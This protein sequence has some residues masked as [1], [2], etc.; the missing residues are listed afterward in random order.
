M[1]KLIFRNNLLALFLFVSSVAL[2]AGTIIPNGVTTDKVNVDNIQLDGNTVSTTNTNGDLTFDMN[3]TGSVIY[4]DL[5]ASAVLSL[6]ASKKLVSGNTLSGLT[7][8]S[9]AINGSN[10]VFGTATN[11]NR[12]RLPT[13][14]TTNLSGLTNTA[15]LLGYDSTLGKPVYNDGTGWSAIGGNFTNPMTTN[16]DMITQAAG[17]PARVGIGTTGYVWTSNGSAPSWGQITDSGI[18][19]GAAIARSK[20]AIGTAG[21]LINDPLFG[22]MSSESQLA[23]IRGGTGVN[24]AGSLTYGANNITLTTSGATSVTLPT[25]GTLAKT[26]SE[27]FT[28]PTIDVEHLT[29]QGSDP[30]TPSAGT[31]KLYAKSTGVYQKDSNGVVS[32]VGSGSGSGKNYTQDLYDGTS[33]VGINQYA[34]AAASSPVDGTGG[35]PGGAAAAIRSS[36][37][38]RSTGDIKL[39]K[40]ANNRQGEGWSYDIVVDESDRAGAKPISFSA[41]VK[42]ST[43]YVTGDL[44]FFV[45][46]KDAPALITPVCFGQTDGTIA[47][48]DTAS[49]LYCT[50]TPTSADDDY[51][52]IIHIATTSA[53]AWDFDLID[54][55]TGVDPPAAASIITPWVAYTPTYTG[56]GTVGTS[57][58][59]SRR[60]GDSL[61]VQGY[62][63]CGVATAVPGQLT[64]G[65]NGVNANV[66]ASNSVIPTN[67]IA[68]AGGIS[69]NGALGYFPLAIQ[70]AGYIQ[71]GLAYT[72]GAGYSI[73]NGNVLCATTNSIS[74]RAS[75]PIAGWTSGNLLSSS[76]LNLQTADPTTATSSTKTATAT[77]RYHAHTGNGIALTPGKWKLGGKVTFFSSGGSAA[78][79]TIGAGFYAANGADTNTAPALLSTLSSSLTV[80][81]NIP[82]G[83]LV[84]LTGLTSS[85]YYV[86]VPEVE[87]RVLSNTTVYLDTYATM[88][89]AANS[90]II[91]YPSAKKIPDFT[92]YG[93]YPT[94][95]TVQK[96]LSGTAQTYTTAPGVRYIR[97]RMVGGG[98]GGA[99][100][101]T[102]AGTSA[103]A[104]GNSSFGTSL[105][106]ANGGTAG[107]WNAASAVGGTASL[108]TGPVG[109][110]VSGGDGQAA[111]TASSSTAAMPGGQGGSS[112]FG[113]AGGGGRYSGAGNAAAT[114]SGSGGGGAGGAAATN[115]LAG[116]GG[117]A[118]GYVDAIIAA[119]L[120]T[121][122][123]SVG[124]AGAA[125]GAGTGG[126]AGANGAAGMIIVEEYY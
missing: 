48:S 121:Y 106:V 24:N 41:T 114:N 125:G 87:V 38:L 120:T 19:S 69:V 75:V 14:T 64:L 47:K 74:F 93:S 71:F 70:N 52:L 60:V 33:V 63:T 102:A 21:V 101:G 4:T 118:G 8:T 95:P 45:Y 91:V 116:P 11:T 112:F 109:V 100:S 59:Y 54:V 18:A 94:V 88:T 56:F 22:T 39:A 104:G 44:K 117:G 79:S 35:S 57:N 15:G 105:L 85:D 40:S 83:H 115:Q 36:S 7:L 67:M 111:G 103:T 108:G 5:T 110:A 6:D 51:R 81:N 65:Y 122:T 20:L 12:L 32:K 2:A 55:K 1:K 86:D 46:N 26:V 10:F 37:A 124:T 119:P 73:T 42:T 53:L 16:G 126:F 34:D 123:Y 23:S 9:P 99:G 78:Y 84:L 113:G 3:G 89:T 28:T 72:S 77:D 58:I 80:L 66:T 92:L 76:A 17:V 30:S 29:E 96:F 31:R 49:Q 90:R 13:E 97:V 61:E 62:F 68:G 25:S 82:S 50:F 107:I 27:S 98:G 43:N